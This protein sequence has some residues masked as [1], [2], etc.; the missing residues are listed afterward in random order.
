VILWRSTK[1]VLFAVFVSTSV[2]LI[3][4]CASTMT[5]KQQFVGIDEKL[6][7]H[8]Y[9]AAL[10][11]V[12]SAKN[13]FY[14]QKDQVLYYLDLGMLSHLDGR[15]GDSNDALT[16][17][18]RA[19]ENAYTRSVSRATASVMLNDN[20][21]EYVGEDYEDVYLNVFKSLNYVKLGAFDDAM[22][23]VR[24]I[25]NK[26]NVL[27][28]RHARMADGYNR[29]EHRGKRF[30]QGRNRFYDSAL[31]RY[32]SMLMYR[33]NGQWDDARIDLDR[34]RDL[35]G[36]SPD[37]YSFRMPSLE[38][39]LDPCPDGY[40]KLNVISFFGRSPD[41]LARTLYIHTQPRAITITASQQVAYQQR[42]VKALEVIPWAGKDPLPVGVQ[43][44][45]QV[46]YMKMRGSRVSRIRLLLNGHEVAT[47]RTIESM[48]KVAYETFKVK[49]PL[50]YLKTITRCVAKGVAR[51]QA[52]AELQ[53]HRDGQKVPVFLI[54]AMFAATENA[55][56]RISQFFPAAAGICEIDVPEGR[57]RVNVVYYDRNGNRLYTDDLGTVDVAGDTLNL[58]QSCY[59]N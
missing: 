6:R 35:W 7:T 31:A 38:T 9:E 57:H 12:R 32:L 15:W 2:I 42:H 24:R 22:V 19:I 37:I 45:F 3:S 55:D 59:L 58:L 18:E 52:V 5:Y 40:A 41:K 8:N 47:L 13:S 16:R 10:S 48:D 21:L 20:T 17:A 44:K 26:L 11:Q 1:P 50:I 53:K 28:D 54:D 46:P 14:K 33:A 56:L 34:I 25:G 27:E 51:A 43:L 23:E 39:V 4:G 49:E 36:R 29:S 30:R